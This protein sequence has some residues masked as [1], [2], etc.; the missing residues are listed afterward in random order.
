MTTEQTMPE[1][2][3]CP[4]CDSKNVRAHRGYSFY[5][6][7]Q[8]CG[9][10]GPWTDYS[11]EEA[12]AAWNRRAAIA[13]T[14][15]EPVGHVDM[16]SPGPGDRI[17]WT[18]GAMPHGTPLYAAPQSAQP[19]VNDALLRAYSALTSCSIKENSDSSKDQYYFNEAKVMDAMQA[20]K[21]FVE[22]IQTAQPAQQP[23]QEG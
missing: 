6:T 23:E 1:L 15:Q 11:S 3:P 14:K 13:A 10:D 19:I 21:P 9:C 16:Q 2:L 12:I 8:D 5:V 18:N 22:A 4:F 7:C 20:L 17:R